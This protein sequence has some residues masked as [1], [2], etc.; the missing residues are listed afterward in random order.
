[1]EHL[2]VTIGAEYSRAM[3][4]VYVALLR[5]INVGGKNTL[6]MKD[7]A[8]MFAK[9]GCTDVK[10][11]IQSGNV[12][13]RADAD[14]AKQV[15]RLVE[16]QILKRFGFRSPVIVRSADQL[17][18]ILAANPFPNTDSNL[19]HIMF[20]ADKP[21]ARAVASL[22]PERS[23]GDSFRVVGREVY[24]HLPNGVARTRF[25]NAWLDSKLATVSTGRNW[26]TVTKLLELTRSLSG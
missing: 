12:I 5:G 4:A 24:L 8:A 9:A 23:P 11:Y 18:R 19:L 3:P 17:D 2:S 15:P 10:T 21:Q 7:L 26:Q 14:C 16:E 6:P 22:D 25:T 20:L 1:M 13:F